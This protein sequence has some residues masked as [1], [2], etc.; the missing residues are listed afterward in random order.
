MAISEKIV[1]LGI[2]GSSFKYL[3]LM[4]LLAIYFYKNVL[5]LLPAVSLFLSTAY[6]LAISVSSNSF[7]MAMFH[8]FY[9]EMAIFTI[10]SVYSLY[11]SEHQIKRQ[12]IYFMYVVIFFAV[13]KVLLFTLNALGINFALIDYILSRVGREPIDVAGLGIVVTGFHFGPEYIFILGFIMFD[14]IK[15]LNE[16]LSSFYKVFLVSSILISM[17]RA[18]ILVIFLLFLF[19]SKGRYIYKLIFIFLMY[20]I[21]IVLSEKREVDEEDL[22]FLEWINAFDIFSNHVLF[23]K[24][25][26]LM[27]LPIFSAY[28][29]IGLGIECESCMVLT[30]SGV[31]G[32]ILF[33][34]LP[35]YSVKRI[36]SVPWANILMPIVLIFAFGFFNPVFSSI[37]C[38]LY[39][40]FTYQFARI[41]T[42]KN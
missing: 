20:G 2:I 13:L 21:Y 32:L 33:F 37:S 12:L 40:Y 17:S 42:A 9:M 19:Q 29:G 41:K 36:L 7:P 25:G 5:L 26:E 30:E 3:I 11:L 22:R 18:Y 38:M 1:Y 24:V 10:L 34:I 4:V 14:R 15:L 35:I 39:F 31:I 23:G 28:T 16:N 6:V 27:S 8:Y